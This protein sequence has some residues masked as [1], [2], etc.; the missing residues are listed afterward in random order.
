ME[1]SLKN[2]RFSLT[3]DGSSGA[4]PKLFF[5]DMVRCIFGALEGLEKHQLNMPEIRTAIRQ[6]LQLVFYKSVSIEGAEVTQWSQLRAI[7]RQRIVQTHVGPLGRL[8]SS[9]GGA[10]FNE[11]SLLEGFKAPVLGHGPGHPQDRSEGGT[12]TQQMEQMMGEA[13]QDPW[14]CQAC[15]M[16]VNNARC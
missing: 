3:V 15:Q 4:R 1:A 9:G 7:L 13:L 14:S 2:E 10:E 8:L 12:A 5:D 6:A 11:S 16:Q